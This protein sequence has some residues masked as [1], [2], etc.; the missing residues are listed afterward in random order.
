MAILAS[1][2]SATFFASTAIPEAASALELAEF[3]VLLAEL[4]VLKA[5]PAVELAALA[6]LFA[7]STAASTS[8]GAGVQSVALLPS[9]SFSH[10]MVII[11]LPFTP[12]EGPIRGMIIFRVESPPFG[13]VYVTQY[14]VSVVLNTKSH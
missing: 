6:V 11:P 5:E 1:A 9:S 14:F 12:T 10:C 13:M 8:S 4:A 3:A 7:A 2:E